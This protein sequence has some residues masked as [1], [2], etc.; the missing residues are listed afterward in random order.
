M[1]RSPLAAAGLIVA[2][3]AFAAPAEAGFVTLTGEYVLSETTD[4]SLCD[5]ETELCRLESFSLSDPDVYAV[6]T[7]TVSDETL[8]LGSGGFVPPGSALTAFEF[9]LQG[10][11]PSDG[12]YTLAD[13]DSFILDVGGPLEL[14]ADLIG[15]ANFLDFNFFTSLGVTGVAPNTLS[16]GGSGGEPMPRSTTL[17][18]PYDLTL[19]SLTVADAAVPLPAAGLLLAPALLGLVGLRRRR[20][21]A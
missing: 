6:V 8:A 15:Q 2:A 21:G 7:F 9:V 4:E 3:S 10:G 13:L 18:E 5:P 12:T 11:G 16:V 19:S 17:I 14:S 20:R 1:F